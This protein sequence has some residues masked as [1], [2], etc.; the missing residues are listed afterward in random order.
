MKGWILSLLVATACILP[1]QS[2]EAAKGRLSVFFAKKGPV[3]RLSKATRF[4]PTRQVS[5]VQKFFPPPKSAKQLV[6]PSKLQI[7]QSRYPHSVAH[8]QAAELAGHPTVLTL[9]RGTNANAR[10]RASLKGTPTKKGFDRDEWPPAMMKEGGK[11]ASIRH[12]PPAD[13]R[14]AGACIGAQCRKL[15]NGT[16][17]I[18]EVVASLAPSLLMPA[19][20]AGA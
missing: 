1:V 19:F 17:V 8:K 12:I 13:N 11:G 2:A 7:S 16:K 14:G 4:A 3:A 15:P 20:N 9:D 10:R 18:I 5:S 6:V